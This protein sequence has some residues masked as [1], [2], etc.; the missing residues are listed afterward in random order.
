MDRSPVKSDPQPVRDLLK[1][2]PDFVLEDVPAGPQL[3]ALSVDVECWEYIIRQDFTN[4]FQPPC[5]DC[6]QQ[7]ESLL[8]IFDAAGVKATFFVLGVFAEGFPELV[9]DIDA[10]GHEIAVHGYTHRQLFKL[11]PDE[12]KRDLARAIGILSD[13]IGKPVIG[14][15]APAFSIDGRTPWALEILVEHGIQ[16][17]SSIF[18]FSGRRYGIPGFP[19]RPVR[20]RWSGGHIIEVP[21][22]TVD[23]AGK[24]L[25]VAGGG[26]FRLLP[27][28]MI[29]WAV[30]RINREAAFVT[31]THPYEFATQS[32]RFGQF[33][34]PM[35]KWQ[36]LFQEIRFNLFR[37]TIQNKILA[38]LR[39]FPFAP[40]R[41][42]IKSGL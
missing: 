37:R 33:C 40:V 4:E 39:E 20:I 9:Q 30:R 21:L 13:I 35:R 7:T 26:Y 15:R 6:R 23:I 25:P 38:L 27:I 14:Y 1:V 34:P 17:D 3:N 22:S 2:R 32:M 24:R 19:R 16:Y 41:E 29:R 11:T 18:P 36:A 5:S 31:Y 8:D 12:F 28:S 42:V 10:R